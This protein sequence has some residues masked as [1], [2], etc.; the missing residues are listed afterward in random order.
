LAGKIISLAAWHIFVTNSF[1]N[2][3]LHLLS[4]CFKVALFSE[5]WMENNFFVTKLHQN[6]A[7]KHGRLNGEGGG[8]A[9]GTCPPPQAF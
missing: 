9:E 5:K 2:V 1:K 6:V 4:Y 7:I 8:G 3:Y